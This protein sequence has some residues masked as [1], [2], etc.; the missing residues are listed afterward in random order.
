[1]NPKPA[2]ELHCGYATSKRWEDAQK[3]IDDQV[4]IPLSKHE[5]LAYT[6]WLSENYHLVRNLGRQM[7]H[8]ARKRIGMGHMSGGHETGKGMKSYQRPCGRCRPCKLASDLE[9]VLRSMWLFL[10]WHYEGTRI[11]V[12]WFKKQ[13]AKVMDRIRNALRQA[14][15]VRRR[16]IW[17]GYLCRDNKTVLILATVP[18]GVLLA[19]DQMRIRS[20]VSSSDLTRVA[21]HAQ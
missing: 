14:V 5:A 8:C 3:E 19:K 9:R 17:Q 10:Q 2:P 12:A 1:M 11:H 20:Q 18:I 6:M 4:D 15:K 16:S 13:N 7:P 21:L